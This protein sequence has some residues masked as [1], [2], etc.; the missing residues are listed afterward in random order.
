[1][2]LVAGSV[3]GEVQVETSRRWA[4]REPGTGHTVVDGVLTLNGDCPDFGFG[5]CDVDQRV[6][7]PAGTRVVVNINAGSVHAADLDLTEFDIEIDSG[8]VHAAA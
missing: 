4:W 5:S 8:S 3:A 2:T 6:T 7:V 1:M